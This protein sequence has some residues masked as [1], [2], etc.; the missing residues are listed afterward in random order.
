MASRHLRRI[1]LLEAEVS[2]NLP[3]IFLGTEAE[4]EALPVK[5]R[6][7][8]DC[9]LPFDRPSAERTVVFLSG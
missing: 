1:E 8:I 2:P 9:V 4:Y 6:G 5:E 7:N 3:V